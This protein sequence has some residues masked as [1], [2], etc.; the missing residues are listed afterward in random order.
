[1]FVLLI[2]LLIKETFDNCF[3]INCI[4]FSKKK[5]VQPINISY[6]SLKIFKDLWN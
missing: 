1:M 2:I 6:P 4:V 3:L 5:N